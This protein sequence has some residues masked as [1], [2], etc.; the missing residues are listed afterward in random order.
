MYCKTF[1]VLKACAALEFQYLRKLSQ[2]WNNW[3]ENNN[4]WRY[5]VIS[6]FYKESFLL[7]IIWKTKVRFLGKYFAYTIFLSV[8]ELLSVGNVSG[9]FQERNLLIKKLWTQFL[10]QEKIKVTCKNEKSQGKEK[11][12]LYCLFTLIF[13]SPPFQGE[14]LQ[15]EKINKIL[16]S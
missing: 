13:R 6:S 14:A 16:E 15:K 1:L 8:K 5:K 3:N 7:N 10:R 11:K 2:Y 9:E 12:R 4:K